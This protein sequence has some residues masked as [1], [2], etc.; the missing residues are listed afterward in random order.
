MVHSFRAVKLKPSVSAAAFSEAI[1]QLS[2][3]LEQQQLL[4][5]TCRIGNRFPRP[6]MDTDE[7][8]LDKFFIMSFENGAQLE[9]K[10]AH[11][12]SSED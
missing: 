1:R 4:T 7:A 12:T 11:M 6:I 8:D 2:T 3:S 9:E 10:V 5:T